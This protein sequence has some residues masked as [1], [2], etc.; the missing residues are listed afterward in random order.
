[1]TF[2]EWL[3]QKGQAAATA[4]GGGT[5]NHPN[6][7]VAAPPPGTQQQLAAYARQNI[8]TPPAMAPQAPPPQMIPPPMPVAPAPRQFPQINHSLNPD[9][10]RAQT[11]P[12]E[13][14]TPEEEEELDK[15]RGQ[16]EKAGTAEGNYR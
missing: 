2:E 6:I 14:L 10:V 13:A 7:P 15:T 1:M 8:S 11:S 5:M 16:T 3:A 4:M 9:N 12:T